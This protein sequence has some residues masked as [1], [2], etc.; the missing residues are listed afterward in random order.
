MAIHL[1]RR[2]RVR[3]SVALFEEIGHDLV[4]S[5]LNSCQVWLSDGG[6]VVGWK[7][8]E[9]GLGR[10]GLFWLHALKEG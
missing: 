3:E 8:E 2:D 1:W 5:Q 4:V 9:K 6:V 10:G 7:G